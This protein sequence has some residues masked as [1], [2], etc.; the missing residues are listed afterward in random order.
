MNPA[1]SVI[2]FTV[3]SGA[4]SGQLAL[5]ALAG[6][7]HGPAST[8]GFAFACMGIALAL[9]TA[10]LLSSTAHLGRPER[11]WRAFLQWRTS[12]LSREGVAAV[13]TY[14]IALAFAI[15]WSGIIDAPQWIAPLG[16]LTALMC[17]VTV[18]CTGMIYAS[19]K[20][21]PAWY[22]NFTVPTYLAFS[23]A[24]GVSV[25]SA[26]S[27]FF[28]RFQNFMAFLALIL[29]FLCIVLKFLYWRKLRRSIGQFTMASATGLGDGVRQWEVPHTATNFIMKEMGFQVARK[30][31]L[32]LQ[33]I[34]MVLLDA[35]FVVMFAS[36]SYPWL[37]LLAA[38]L[39]LV[40]A[41][42]E[43]WLFFAQAEHVVGLFY[44][45]TRV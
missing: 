36:A 35:S 15:C 31:A 3:A 38:P 6:A 33:Q 4:G 20:T 32:R 29:I 7:S 27:Y 37:T 34:A 22:S 19:L 17:L 8:R 5:T 41:W 21:I 12:W 30:S 44:G 40:A 13:L 9:I 39:L 28:G 24:T 2:F 45:K 26:I 42:C 25:L 10:G 23:L 11:A 1:Y 43:R 14:P 18:V 16:Y